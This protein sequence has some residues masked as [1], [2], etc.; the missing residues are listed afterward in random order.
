MEKEETHQGE[1]KN[2][3]REKNGNYTLTERKKESKREK[4]RFA[5][6]ISN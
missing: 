2:A 5:S 3:K 6:A 4:S 1:P